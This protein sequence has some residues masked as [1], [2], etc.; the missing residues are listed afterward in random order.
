MK[1]ANTGSLIFLLGIFFFLSPAHAQTKKNCLVR[2]D[3]GYSQ[4]QLIV[5]DGKSEDFVLEKR[6][7]I[8][9]A[10]NRICMI[11]EKCYIARGDNLELHQ[12]GEYVILNHKNSRE[13]LINTVR[14]KLTKSGD[15]SNFLAGKDLDETEYF[16]MYLGEN[17]NT[18]KSEY[19]FETFPKYNSEGYVRPT[20][21]NA[22]WGK[23]CVGTRQG[24]SG[25][26]F[27]PPD[28]P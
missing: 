28:F 13:G 20:D 3:P 27:D 12:L 22:N 9:K 21:L 1:K 26:G 5:N 25:N 18:G 6:I 16:L 4:E 23:T 10:E 15:R 19:R 17:T 11:N 2:T 8:T 7:Q 14:L 24:G